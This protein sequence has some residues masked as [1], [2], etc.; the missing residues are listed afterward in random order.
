MSQNSEIGIAIPIVPGIMPITN[1]AN[2]ARFSNNCG[3]QI[4]RWLDRRLRGFGDD[5]DALREFG[6]EVVTT[7]CE[8]LLQGGAPGLHFYSMNLSRSVSRIWHNLSL[9]TGG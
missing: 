7:L 8:T 1:Y 5:S 4:P 2:L 3:A 6:I 9:P